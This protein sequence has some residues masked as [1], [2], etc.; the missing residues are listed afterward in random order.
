M[1]NLQSEASLNSHEHILYILFIQIITEYKTACD[2]SIIICWDEELVLDKT[3]HIYIFLYCNLL[4]YPTLRPFIL[5]LL[6]IVLPVFLQFTASDYSFDI[7]RYT[8]KIKE[9][10]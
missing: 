10:K 8:V 3:N 2:L 6:A 1:S 5:I 9:N 7:L 4:K